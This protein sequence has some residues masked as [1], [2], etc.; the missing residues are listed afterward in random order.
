MNT[1]I[2][3]GTGQKAKWNLPEP[4]KRR[5]REQFADWMRMKNYKP[6]TID[7]YV[8]NVLDFVRH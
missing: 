8:A 2:T 3:E 5:L 6:A 7:A 4:P 1:A